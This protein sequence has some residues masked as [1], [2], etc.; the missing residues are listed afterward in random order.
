MDIPAAK[1]CESLWLLQSTSVHYGTHTVSGQL[2]RTCFRALALAVPCAS[3]DSA[4]TK[5]CVLVCLTAALSS[6]ATYTK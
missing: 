4:V 1:R 5:L 2:H 6:Q 3:A